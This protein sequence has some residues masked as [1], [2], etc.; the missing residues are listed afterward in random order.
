VDGLAHQLADGSEDQSLAAD[1]RLAGKPLADD[2][3]GEMGLTTRTMPSMAD[4][5]LR[6]VAHDQMYRLQ[7]VAQSLLDLPLY[8]SHTMISRLRS[9][10]AVSDRRRS[11]VEWLPD[12]DNQAWTGPG[13]K[14]SDHRDALPG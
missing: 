8:R 13:V 11:L 9:A 4:M 10:A 3:D 12:A 1:S 5:Q 7:L 6:F 2:L 14:I